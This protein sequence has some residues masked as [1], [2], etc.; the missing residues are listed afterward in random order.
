M[1]PMR[2]PSRTASHLALP[3]LVIFLV[4]AC[5]PTDQR[6]REGEHGQDAPPRLE[7]RPQVQRL[8]DTD[9]EFANPAARY[10]P[11]VVTDEFNPD[12]TDEERENPEPRRGGS[13]RIRTPANFQHFNPIT[14]TGQPERV[15]IQHLSDGLIAQDLETLE[16]IPEKA[17][18]WREADIV[19]TRGEEPRIGRIIEKDDE[20]VIF[21]PD[22]WRATYG[23]QDVEEM[24]GEQGHVILTS[25]RGGAHVE[26]R[27]TLLDHTVQVDE[28][29]QSAKAENA[30]TIPVEDLDTWENEIG[31]RTET[32]LF[33]KENCAFEFYIREGVKWHD[34][35]PFSARDV[36]FGFEMIMNPAVDAQH[37][38]NYFQDVESAEVFD[39]GMAIRFTYRKPY[40]QAISILGGVGSPYALPR[41]VIRPEQYGGDERALGQAFNNHE[42]KE[43]PIYTGPF[44]LQEWRRGDSLTIVRNEDYWKNDP[45]TGPL[46]LWSTE[47]PHL[48]RITWVVYSEAT[49]A[50]RDLINRTID[51]DLDVEPTTWNQPDT[52]SQLFLDRMVRAK[53]PG[54]LYTYIGWNLENPLFQDPEVRRA[55]AMLIP[56]QEIADSVHMGAAFP[57]D[58]PFYFAGPGYD[59]TVQPIG[60]DHRGATRILAR[61]GWLD[62]S[63]DGVLENEQDGQDLRFRFRYS[64]H[65]AREYHQKIADI[66]AERMAEAKI[67]MTIDRMDWAI[68]AD[69]VR[70][71]NFDAVRFAWGTALEP[72]PFQIFHSSQIENKGDNFVSYR[73]PRVDELSERIRETMDPEKRWEMAREVHR[74]IH[75]DQPYCFLFGFYE[76]Y[77]IHRGLRG[78]K[79][80]PGQYPHNFTEWWWDEIPEN[81]R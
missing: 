48:D 14:S 12:V 8:G 51:V 46:P 61:K 24:D 13:L 43:R 19:K 17:W 78:V 4:T 16:Y 35:E 57:V 37:R 33:A 42:F 36:E 64:I 53:R 77:F 66:I 58:G 28:G 81:R 3:A 70:D 32:R 34:G 18:Y 21:V 72:D 30:I 63:L 39:D 31:D 29:F 59:D 44:R 47:Q 41:H 27:L 9:R 38:R 69:A 5:T 52:Q 49:A 55:L 73:N 76:Q 62:R 74:I 15:I 6:R 56:R 50:V 23:L 67:Q 26:G 65:N 1:N 80:Y 2:L 11:V 45:A 25:E 60:F 54:F 20:R 71:K 7:G 40:F 10:L 68:F 22:A 75:E 79:L